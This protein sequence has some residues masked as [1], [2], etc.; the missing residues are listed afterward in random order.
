MTTIR[1]ALA[2]SLLPAAALAQ[3][4]D[5]Q[6][7]SSLGGARE[8][9]AHMRALKPSGFV[10]TTQETGPNDPL[11]LMQKP[12]LDLIR[13]VEP[14]VTVLV[15]KD[16]DGEALCTGFFVDARA[17]GVSGPIVA[18]NSHC[19]E[20]RRVGDEIELGLFDGN[21]NRPKFV[22]AR[23]AAY[24]DSKAAKDL[25]FVRLEDASLARR[26]LP[27]WDKLDVGE[28]VVAIGN[29]RGFFFSVSQGIVSALD[30]SQIESEFVLSADQ[31]DAA[32]NPGNSGGPLFNMWGSVVGI[33]AMISSE[34]GGFEGLS[35]T[36]PAR[37][38]RLALR[39]F[40]R[41]GNLKIGVMETT[42]AA[43]DSGVYLRK[44]V[45][46]GPA[47]A[48][49]VKDGDRVLAVDGRSLEGMDPADA[50]EELLATVK[51]MSPGETVALSLSRGGKTLEL[52]VVLGAP[53]PARPKWAPLP[54]LAPA[55][56]RKPKKSA[57]FI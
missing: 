34:S 33:N 54:K 25:A 10:Q 45:A 3:S 7:S 41:T 32:V 23:V 43:E 38:V 40:A 4:A 55:R 15:T 51:Y 47:A 27:L 21:D 56:P 42:I 2:L 18:T 13:K 35:F 46:D 31:T 36:V 30:R 28:Q 6:F 29:P 50:L 11:L 20:M 1:A 8:L 49:G 52:R 37:F 12:M 5:S 24:G 48:A 22:K 39:Q 57:Y 9:V 17:E 14:S 16:G 26:P 19:V 44:P 53:K